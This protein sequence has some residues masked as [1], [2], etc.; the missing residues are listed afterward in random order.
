M[1]SQAESS[2]RSES[3]LSRT[4]LLEKVRRA[5][6]QK[7]GGLLEL[8]R[9]YLSVLA[10]GQ[11]DRKLRGRVSASDLVQETMMEAH[12]DF[13]QFRGSSE[14]EF[15]SWL[16]RILVNNMARA[17]EMHV[18][19][20][21]R[22]VRR[23]VSIERLNAAVERS[24]I[25]LGLAF[26]GREDSPSAKFEQHE[27]AIDLANQMSRL[28][29]EHREVLVLRN[30]QSLPFKEVAARMDRTIPAAKMLWMR[31]IKKLRETYEEQ[32]ANV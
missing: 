18:L 28:S 25:Q 10:T 4:D 6:P 14:P 2:I 31:A 9:N 13:H 12:R 5:D 29:P 22:D 3:S 21:K 16:R 11:L 30:L 26:A 8:Y 19:A 32:G 27:R 7:L 24:T 20:E 1:L 17:I 23:E 15:I